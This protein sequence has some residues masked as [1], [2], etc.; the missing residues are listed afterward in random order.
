MDSVERLVKTYIQ[1]C[2]DGCLLF[3]NWTVK[4]YFD[5][6]RGVCC[7]VEF[8]RGEGTKKQLKGKQ[9]PHTLEAY[10]AKVRQQHYKPSSK[11]IL[12][13]MYTCPCLDFVQ[14]ICSE[15]LSFPV[16]RLDCCSHSKCWWFKWMLFWMIPP[17]L[18]RI[19]MVMHHCEPDCHAKRL[20]FCFQGWGHNKGFYNQNM[21]ALF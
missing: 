17:E 2:R 18:F 11:F 9:D 6:T 16:K 15:L 1:L 5:Q 14:M 10:M 4:L 19:G 13:I 12:V 3:L 8:F 21:S 7:I 20:Y